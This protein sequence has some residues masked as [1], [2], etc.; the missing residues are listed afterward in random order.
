MPEW[1]ETSQYLTGVKLV[2][3]VSC[4]CLACFLMLV[5]TM[6]VSTAIPR[7]IDDFDSL[8]DIGW[9]ATAYQF[10]SAAPQPLSGKIFANFNNRYA[11]LACFVTFE[12]GSALCGAATSSAIGGLIIMFCSV[13]MDKCPGLIGVVMGLNQLG[14]VIGPLIGGAFTSYSTWRWCFYVN[15]QIGALVVLA[16]F[17]FP[18]PEQTHKPPAMTVLHRIHKYLDLVGFFLFAPAVLQL[19]MALKFGGVMFPWNSSQVIGLF[20][21]FL[22]SAVYGPIFYLPIYFQAVNNALPLLSGVYLLPAILPQL[23][24]A[25][26][27]GGI[28]LSRV[29]DL[30]DQTSFSI[31]VIG[32]LLLHSITLLRPLYY[33]ATAFMVFTQSL[34]PA[35]ILTLCQVIFYSTLRT[36]LPKKAPNANDEAMI[37]AGATEFRDIVSAD[38]LHGVLEAYANSISRVFYLVAVV[39][40]AYILVMWGWLKLPSKTVLQR[41]LT[42]PDKVCEKHLH[43]L[44]RKSA[45]S[46]ELNVQS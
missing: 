18:I 31:L 24:M 6:V 37:A 12:V 28:N 3:V 4:M 21:A 10:G 46:N 34:G 45:V 27:S 13:P 25:A 5:D 8:A 19:I 42:S 20:C 14:L 38:V 2:M 16:L 30:L 32:H 41:K 40:A 22:M 35:I 9:Y 17:L 36:E 7:I 43:V 33:T 1:D 15:L 23:V 11:F 39:A 44:Y 26:A 29:G